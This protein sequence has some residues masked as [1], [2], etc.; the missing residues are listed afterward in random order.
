[1]SRGARPQPFDRGRERGLGLLAAAAFAAGSG[2]LATQL[3]WPLALSAPLTASAA[4]LPVIIAEQRARRAQDELLSKL[5]DTHA[6]RKRHPKRL[7]FVDDVSLKELRVHE[8]QLPVPFVKRDQ[9]ALLSESIGPGRSVLLVGHSL[10]GKT[11]LAAEVMKSSLPKHTLLIPDRKEPGLPQLLGAGLGGRD[12]V[13]WLDDIDGYLSQSS[14]LSL[15]ALE[16]FVSRGATL[17]ATINSHA[18]EALRPQGGIRSQAWEVLDEFQR[19]DLAR[20]LTPGELVRLRECIQDEHL[21]EQMRTYGLGEYLAAG[22]EALGRLSDNEEKQPTG[23]ALVRI[24]VDWRRVGL[25]RPVPEKTLVQLLPAY[26]QRRKDVRL[27]DGAV[28]QGLAWATEEINSAVALL[29]YVREDEVARDA[30]ER[31]YRPFEYVVDYFSAHSQEL[32]VPEAMWSEAVAQA[33]VNECAFIAFAAMNAGAV[34]AALSAYRKAASAGDPDAMVIL[35]TLLITASQVD[36][37]ATWLRRAHQLGHGEALMPLAAVH[38]QRGD[39]SKAEALLRQAI[40]L[41]DPDAEA[42]LGAL[43]LERGERAAGRLWLERAAKGGHEVAEHLLPALDVIVSGPDGVEASVVAD[44]IA[45]LE[46]VPHVLLVLGGLVK[47]SSGDLLGAVAL[48]T[49][50]AEAGSPEAM[51]NL[52]SVLRQQGQWE[53]A[54]SWYRRGMAQGHRGCISGLAGLLEA[55]G[56]LAEAEQ[57]YNRAAAMKDRRATRRL[58]WLCHQRGDFIAAEKFYMEAAAL[59]DGAAMNWLGIRAGKEERQ[60][61]AETWYRRAADAGHLAGM[62]NLGALLERAGAHDDEAE[63]WYREGARLQDPIAMTALGCL[64]HRLG[65]LGEAET[66]L[67]R[68]LTVDRPNPAVDPADVERARARAMSALGMILVAGGELG[69]AEG[70]YA[71]AAAAGRA[72]AANNLGD[73]YERKGRLE[74][75]ESWYREAARAGYALAYAGVGDVLVKR[76]APEEAEVWYR[77]GAELGDELSRCRLEQQLMANGKLQEAEMWRQRSSPDQQAAPDVRQSAPSDLGQELDGLRSRV[78]QLENAVALSKTAVAPADQAHEA[79]ET[80]FPNV[81]AFVVEELLPIYRRTVRED[82][83][84]CAQ[85]WRHVEAVS[86]LEALWRAWERLRL[87]P[88]FGMATWYRDFFDVSWPQI[89]RADGPAEPA[90]DDYWEWSDVDARDSSN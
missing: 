33:S 64:Y 69:E 31:K 19:I 84:W 62:V 1:V 34:Q 65:R 76:N 87:D 9:Q 2:T 3:Q 27:D 12:L 79:I 73:L 53:D 32:P 7:P 35:G 40:R 28:Q 38:Q 86:R 29:Q 77:Q 16:Q 18:R 5:I 20:A 89:T 55:R 74:E 17:I 71:Q 26:L 61:L 47:E 41:G 75:A 44:R 4:V 51:V 58:G 46:G 66:W 81:E 30:A 24:A 10:A 36:E 80:V 90:P 63:D 39:F 13:V 11:R 49:P 6:T 78:R 15:A 45:G 67:R 83:R 54:E 68:A 43:L 59:G 42:G 85:W 48:Y 22:P 82:F 14:G 70:W 21:L 23:C 88:A 57:L 72:E 56:R 37:A 60:D 52:A 25:N 8:A 50:A